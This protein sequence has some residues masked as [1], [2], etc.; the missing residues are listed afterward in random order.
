MCSGEV[1]FYEVLCCFSTLFPLGSLD[2]G[3]NTFTADVVL[4]NGHLNR[5]FIHTPRTATWAGVSVCSCIHMYH[6][7]WM[8][9]CTSLVILSYTF[10]V[11]PYVCGVKVCSYW[12]G[13]CICDSIGHK[14]WL[15]PLRLHPPP[16]PPLLP[17][18]SP[19]L[20]L[21]PPLPAS[22]PPLPSATPELIM[23]GGG[24]TQACRVCV[25]SAQLVPN[26]SFRKCENFEIVSLFPDALPNR[27]HFPV[28][29]HTA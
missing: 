16:L 29:V 9:G 6:G 10:L 28:K 2:S 25:H 27:V 14:M 26:W 4:K 23:R 20:L 7:R 19:P 3:G 5:Y 18:S 13:M 8:W 15:M 24:L 11:C 17:T 12:C 22:L 21:L 1:S